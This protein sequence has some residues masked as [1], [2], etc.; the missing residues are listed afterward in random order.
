MRLRE[1]TTRSRLYRQV[2]ELGG[3]REDDTSTLPLCYDIL[4]PSPDHPITTFSFHEPGRLQALCDGVEVDAGCVEVD[5]A[6]VLGGH[7]RL[8]GGGLAGCGLALNNH[9]ICRGQ[10]TGASTGLCVA[11]GTHSPPLP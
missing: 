7:G 6:S 1:P 5:D 10:Y 8:R 4:D 9:W 3:H 2:T 11:F